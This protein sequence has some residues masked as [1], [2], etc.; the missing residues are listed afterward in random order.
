LTFKKVKL[1]WFAMPVYRSEKLRDE[2]V[3]F[4]MRSPLAKMQLDTSQR[5]RVYVE[6][7]GSLP[8][9]SNRIGYVG[10]TQKL[11]STPYTDTT[12]ALDANATY[13]GTSRD[14]QI[15]SSSPYCYY[16]TIVAH[17]VSDQ[18]GTLMIQ[19]SPDGSTWVTVRN[20]ATSSLTNPDSTTVQVAY[21]EHKIA[22]RYVRV[23]YRNG[24]TA[25]ATFRLSSRVVG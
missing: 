17:A 15:D 8:S 2:L 16:G 25:Q 24:A 19:E 4:L 23:A 12:T 21:I 1:R 13:I 10:V 11:L 9:G 5:A 20:V 14:T 6:S 18:A 7:M 22:L 3:D